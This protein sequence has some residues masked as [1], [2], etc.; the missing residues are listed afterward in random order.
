MEPGAFQERGRE[1]QSN[2]KPGQYDRD[3]LYNGCLDNDCDKNGGTRRGP[4]DQRSPV[5]TL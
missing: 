3:N 5:R 4:D 2:D 1:F